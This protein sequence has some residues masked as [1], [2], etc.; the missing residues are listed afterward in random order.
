M[1]SEKKSVFLNP[2]SMV[3]NAGKKQLKIA[4]I[5]SCIGLWI[6]G[7]IDLFFL[8]SIGCFRRVRIMALGECWGGKGGTD[9]ENMKDGASTDCVNGT[10]K[11]CTNHKF[12]VGKEHANYIYQIKC[13]VNEFYTIDVGCIIICSI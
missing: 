11:E 2:L 8:L 13:Q 6:N 12:C 10:F 3:L 7:S 1:L 5:C 9:V 4:N